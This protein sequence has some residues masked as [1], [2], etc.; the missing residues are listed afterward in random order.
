MAKE[1]TG[2]QN[3]P[4]V[5]SIKRAIE[6]SEGAFINKGISS[7]KL[8]N[9]GV[10][11]AIEHKK[12]TE[13]PNPTPIREKV[14]LNN[15]Q[16]DLV[17]NYKLT[18][19]GV[20]NIP[21]KIKVSKVSSL[22]AFN[23]IITELK[24]NE[25]VTSAVGMG[26][27]YNIVNGSVGF[28]NRDLAKKITTKIDFEVVNEIGEIEKGSLEFN[29]NARIYKKAPFA[30]SLETGAANDLYSE[31]ESFERLSGLIS[32]Y[33][34]KEQ[35]SIE[36]LTLNITTTFMIGGGAYI[37][38]S[39][40]FSTKKDDKEKE[41]YKC[42]SFKKSTKEPVFGL[43]PEKISNA[44]RT[45]DTF[46]DL[47]VNTANPLVIPIEPTGTSTK[48]FEDFRS[49]EQKVFPMI[50]KLLE[51]VNSNK[52]ISTVLNSEEL[53]YVYMNLVRGGLFQNKGK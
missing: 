36:S 8:I 47:N 11:G 49:D 43:S 20:N 7:E 30:L 45:V 10:K 32:K 35:D 42:V 17:L 31:N 38:P 3:L 1:K 39:E 53:F 18:I 52:E 21:D 44:I 2:L 5:L 23:K 13:G 6:Y 34:V 22:E 16:D 48:F 12:D 41:M 33:I 27:A 26:I 15:D 28:R 9:V 46:Y 29:E 37:Y 40:L 25:I 24:E 19:L 14:F 51:A 4:T 50:D